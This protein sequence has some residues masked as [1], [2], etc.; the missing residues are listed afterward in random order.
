MEDDDPLLSIG[1][2]ARRAR[3]SPKALRLYD[4]QGLFPGRACRIRHV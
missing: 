4:R 3:L 2:F 1:V